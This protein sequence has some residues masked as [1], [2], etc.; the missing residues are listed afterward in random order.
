MP[1]KLLETFVSISFLS[2]AK[3]GYDKGHLNLCPKSTT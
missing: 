1:K 3:T 2:E